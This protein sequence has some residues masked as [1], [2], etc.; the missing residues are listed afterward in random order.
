V[1][2]SSD[3]TLGRKQSSLAG[4]VS[5]PFVRVVTEGQKG[6]FMSLEK[7]AIRAMVLA[8]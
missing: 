4:S 7:S 5:L 3:G 2:R 1:G 6:G 8:G